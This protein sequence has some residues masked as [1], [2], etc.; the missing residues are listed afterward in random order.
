MLRSGV[1]TGPSVIAWGEKLA[2]KVI[3][4]SLIHE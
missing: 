1:L 2:F 4:G 3:T